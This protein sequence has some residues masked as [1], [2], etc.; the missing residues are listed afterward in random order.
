MRLRT[1][2]FIHLFVDIIQ[3][4][5]RYGDSKDLHIRPSEKSDWVR[6][7]GILRGYWRYISLKNR[8]ITGLQ[9][10]RQVIVR[11]FAFFSL[12]RSRSRIW[13]KVT[14]W[15]FRYPERFCQPIPVINSGEQIRIPGAC[16]VHRS[17][18]GP[19]PARRVGCTVPRSIPP[20]WLLQH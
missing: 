15:L 12:Y 3:M 2:R 6:L 11:A 13:R 14:A 8:R 1:R 18:P 19:G 4:L 17:E 5:F 16:S 9:T 7:D 20:V 10:P